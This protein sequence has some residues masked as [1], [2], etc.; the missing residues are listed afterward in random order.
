MKRSLVIALVLSSLACSIAFARR[1]A[2]TDTD[3]PPVSL[4]T[5]L[6]L[7][8]AEL[9][10][11]GT[12]YPCVGASLAKT[13]SEGDWEFHFASKDGKHM[14]VSVGSDRTVQKRAGGF[15]HF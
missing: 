1:I 11:E 9:K 5:A 8:E 3:P 6:D 10:T 4:R 14:H 12:K 15:E 7:A 2:W 13:F